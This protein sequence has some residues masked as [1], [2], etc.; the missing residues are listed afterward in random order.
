MRFPFNILLA[1]LFCAAFPSSSFAQQGTCTFRPDSSHTAPAIPEAFGVNIDFT[2]AAPGEMKML[3]EAGFRWVR[4]DLKWD[5][6]E[7]AKEQYDFAAYDKLMAE[8]KPFG[9]RAL[10][11]LDYTNPLYDGGAPPRTEAGRQA[12]ARWAVSAAKHFAGNGV[13]WETYNEPNHPQFWPPRPSPDD[14][15]A[16]ALAVA[17]AFRETV[18]DEKLIGPATSEVDFE[19]L[20]ACFKGGLLDYWTAVSV[21]PYRRSDPETAAED[22]CRLRKL[23]N[24]YGPPNKQ[25]EIIA[26]E[27]GYSSAWRGVSREKQGELLARSWLTNAAHN[28]SLSIWYDWRDDGANANEAEHNFG[29]VT[30]TYHE[31]RDPVYK[32]KPAYLAAKALTT[33]FNGYRFERRV[34]LGSEDF[35]LVFSNGKSHRIAAWTTAATHDVVIPMKPGSYTSMDHLGQRTFTLKADPR[36]LA[37]KLSTSPTYL[38]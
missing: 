4:M 5:V 11:I 18:P 33:F 37:L 35:V 30:H 15:V 12:F 22:Y 31:N 17:R 13:I 1:F 6:T 9:I 19:F 20:E 3:A 21:H 27:W 23:I 29:T 38:R 28:V 8:L 10:F 2:S 24:A 36:G 14:Y 7:P 34:E 32:P 26:G 25:I 16:L